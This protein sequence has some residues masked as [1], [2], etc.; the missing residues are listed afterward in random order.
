MRTLSQIGTNLDQITNLISA[1]DKTLQGIPQRFPISTYGTNL[2]V[3]GSYFLTTN[4]YS[5]AS[6][7]DGINIRTN[8]NNITIDL[9]GFGIFNTN[10]P[11]GASPV[12][13]RIS[14]ATNIVVRNGQMSGMDRGVRAEGLFYGIVVENIHVSNVTRAG[15]E[16]NG[17]AGDASQTMTVRNCVIEGVDGTGEGTNVSVDGIVVLNC[18]G[19]V[20]NCVV[21]DITSVGVGTATCI[22]AISATNTFVNN[23]YLSRAQVGLS[24]SGGGT[25]VYYRN[26][27]TAG[28][29]TPFSS[30]G[31]VDRG[32][33]F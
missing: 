33:N 20:D 18:T 10:A 21:R 9:N 28:C 23:N 11:S 1:V 5:G 29:A 12:G 19:L 30:N 8:I 7:G 3:P 17:V 25:R 31:G 4:L 6:T 2:T 27:L 13:V 26:N 22:D 14:A 16:G 15:I 24:I 32:G